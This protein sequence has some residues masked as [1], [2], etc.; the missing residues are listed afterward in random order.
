MISVLKNQSKYR[1]IKCFKILHSKNLF[2]I[3]AAF[4]DHYQEMILSL[5]LVTII[6]FYINL[7]SFNF[8]VLY[9]I[10]W[11]SFSFKVLLI[12][13]LS[14]KSYCLF[15]ALVAL[16]INKKPEFSVHQYSNKNASR[17]KQKSISK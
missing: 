5:K 1:K 13:K 9:S 10:C 17:G 15:Q 4:I 3:Y 2:Y 8:L 7:I 11:L 14:I 6:I 12:M 16:N